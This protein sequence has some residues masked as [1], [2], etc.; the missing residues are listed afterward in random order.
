M[1]F[2][3]LPTRPTQIEY[4]SWNLYQN[5]NLSQTIIREGEDMTADFSSVFVVYVM[6]EGC[7]ITL[8]LL[9][10]YVRLSLTMLIVGILTNYKIK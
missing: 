8:N 4:V 1:S 10:L 6:H 9:E 7:F 2:P 5:Y 3:D